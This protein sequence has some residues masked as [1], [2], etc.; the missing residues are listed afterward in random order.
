M[1]EA[2][3]S[4]I[5]PERVVQETMTIEAR[6]E[7]RSAAR[8]LRL[9]EHERA[10]GEP[11]EQALARAVLEEIAN[12][13]TGA[14]EVIDLGAIGFQLEQRT[15][16]YI[17]DRGVGQAILRLG[18]LRANRSPSIVEEGTEVPNLV[19]DTLN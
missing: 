18:Q 16:P 4:G 10:P 13:L 7:L 17:S 6:S 15:S 3:G 11:T 9:I 8:V 5:R 1:A 14:T 12:V 2:R 19:P